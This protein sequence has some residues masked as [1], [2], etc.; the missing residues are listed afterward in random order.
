MRQALFCVLF[1]DDE[2][3]AG[4]R[5]RHM[6]AHLAFLAGHPQIIA[7]GPLAETAKGAGGMWLVRGTEA[8][9]VDALVKADPFWSTGLRKSHRILEW[10]LVHGNV[11]A[12]P[13]A[14]LAQ[15]VEAT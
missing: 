7:A 14:R 10:R 9:A 12:D 2:A 5:Q 1:E 13:A 15:G 6:Q 8:A 4:M 3:F 11:H